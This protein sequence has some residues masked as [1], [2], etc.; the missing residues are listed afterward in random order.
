MQ[1][2]RNQYRKTY[3]FDNGYG[4]SVICNES[5]YGGDNGL[6]ELAVLDKNGNI[7]YDTPITSDVIGY[8]THDHVVRVLKDIESL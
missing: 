5:S 1:S 7:C 3:T 4:A 6:F 2:E 8:M